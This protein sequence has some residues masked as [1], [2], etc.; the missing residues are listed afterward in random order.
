MATK[1]RINYILLQNKHKANKHFIMDSKD[2]IVLYQ[3]DNTLQLEVRVEDETVW[4][5]QAQM[6][7]LF[8][9]DKSVISRHITNIYKE[10]ELEESATVA[11]FATVQNENECK[12][13]LLLQSNRKTFTVN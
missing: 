11:N 10:K 13:I 7:A 4:L 12:K 9:R 2:K 1:L 6:V 3:P 5:T 8:G